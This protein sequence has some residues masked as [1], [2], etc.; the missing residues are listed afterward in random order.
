MA[1]VENGKIALR[2]I[3]LGRDL[4]TAVE[5]SE[6]VT[7]AD[8][9]VVNPSDALTTGVAVTV[10]AALVDDSQEHSHEAP[11]SHH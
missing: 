10:T 2:T 7:A 6:G 1:L 9:V 5:V 4:G 8:Q 3:V 11:L